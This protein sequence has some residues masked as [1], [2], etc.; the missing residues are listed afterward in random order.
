VD[1]SQYLQYPELEL[2]GKRALVTGASSG[3]GL[4]IACRLA[5]EGVH[6][7]LVA[8][9]AE[10]LEALKSALLERFP[11]LT[12][13]T[14][15]ADL[16]A[17]DTTQKLALMNALDVDIVINNA[18]LARGLDTVDSA[19]FEHWE[20]MID[21]N[22]TAAFRIVHA[23]LPHLIARG[24]GHIVMMS[25]IAGHESYEK[26][27]VYCAT[28]HAVNAFSKALRMETCDKNIRVSTISPGLA[29]TEFSTVR[30]SG[31]EA[32][33]NSVYQ[34]VTPLNAA[35]IAHEVLFCLKQ[36][37]HVNINEV[38]VLPTAQGSATK[39]FRK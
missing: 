3:F 10:K 29:Q 35:D 38:V 19:K 34:G 1:V 2:K 26:G 11:H 25:S 21:T 13:N 7:N 16:R 33:A 14:L 31:D 5:A 28:K 4:A 37:S 32:R 22:V 15:A 20:E 24:R 18:G 39:V 17:P 23:T 6:L 8:R 36:P 12:I 27:S 30:F 9:R